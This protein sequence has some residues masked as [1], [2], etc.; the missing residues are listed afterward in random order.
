MAIAEEKSKKSFSADERP[1]PMT[2]GEWMTHLAMEV[3]EEEDAEEDEAS[4]SC[5]TS[6]LDLSGAKSQV[7]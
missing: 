7:E 2:V 5:A 3:A 1:I 4:F 6:L